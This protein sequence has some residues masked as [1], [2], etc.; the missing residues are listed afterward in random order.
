MRM[1]YA[2]DATNVKSAMAAYV[3]A[4]G[5]P[6]VTAT[7]ANR[8]T[9]ST[10]RRNAG[11]IHRAGAFAC[12]KTVNAWCSRTRPGGRASLRA[13]AV[14]ARPGWTSWGTGGGVD[15]RAAA[16]SETDQHH[17]GAGQ[18]DAHEAQGHDLTAGERERTT[19]RRP[20]AR[21]P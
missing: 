3:S 11:A 1:R 14:R 21:R 6:P 15:L 8:A 16:P 19:A 18:P 7:P 17:A 20:A 10:Q 9:L 4:S 5:D 2:F 12:R 13:G